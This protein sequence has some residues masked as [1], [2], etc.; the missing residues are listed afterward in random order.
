V[1]TDYPDVHKAEPLVAKPPHQIKLLMHAVTVDTD[2]PSVSAACLPA[3]P[4]CRTL[5]RV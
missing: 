4:V 3:C 1:S 2:E 5:H